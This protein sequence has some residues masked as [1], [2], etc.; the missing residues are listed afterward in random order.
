MNKRYFYLQFFELLSHANKQSLLPLN[1]DHRAINISPRWSIYTIEA[2][3]EGPCPFLSKTTKKGKKLG[4]LINRQNEH[5]FASQARFATRAYAISRI[6]IFRKMLKRGTVVS[7]TRIDIVADL[8][9][10]LGVYSPLFPLANCSVHYM[11]IIM[12]LKVFKLKI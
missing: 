10:A 9:K 6:G 11:N 8:W 7:T 2:I 1:K 4:L 3:F 12:I 5:C